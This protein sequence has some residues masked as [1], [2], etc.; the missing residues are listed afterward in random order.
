MELFENILNYLKKYIYKEKNTKE[1]NTNTT[2]IIYGTI[3]YSIFKNNN[4]NKVIVFADMHDTLKKC[5]KYVTIGNWLKKKSEDSVILLE[6]VDREETKL[7]SLWPNSPHTEELKNL[8]LDNKDVI[9]PVDIRPHLIPFSWE[10][11]L[12]FSHKNKSDT[13]ML[14]K[15]W[16]EQLISFFNFN[17]NYINSKL[18]I[19]NDKEIME[20]FALIK[21]TFD[22]FL[23]KNAKLLKNTVGFIAMSNSNFVDIINTILSDAMEW[24]TCALIK[25]NN[26]KLVIMHAGLAHTTKICDLLEK[27]YKYKNIKNHGFVKYSETETPISGCVM[28]DESI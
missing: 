28:L 4:N 21:I 19:I 10:M 16:L 8:Y 25:K 24:Y 26:S 13:N 6:E 20:H 12:N 2:E 7:M 23:K 9:I 11:L 22:N 1:I 17:N 18:G 5:S 14:F 15:D 27:I 3:G